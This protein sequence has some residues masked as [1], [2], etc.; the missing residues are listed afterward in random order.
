MN[1][2]AL[3]QEVSANFG[4][5]VETR[6]KVWVNA[7][8]QEWLNRR[9]WSYLETT[10][11]A[12]ALVA[13][14]QNYVLLGSSPVVTDYNGMI[15][16]ELEVTASGARVPLR[17]FDPQ[18]FVIC[19]SHS[20]VN[21]VPAF[22]ATVGG[23]AQVSAAT[24]LSGGNQ[25]LALW[26]IPIATAGNGVNVFLRYTRMVSETMLMTATTDVPIIPPKDHFALV[27]GAAAIGFETFGQESQAQYAR[28]K[29]QQRM[30][31]AAI[32]DEGMRMR[33]I[34]RVQLVQQPWQYPIT[35]APQNGA[36]AANDPYPVKH[37]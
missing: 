6:A 27:H 23:T 1:F 21:G 28:M 11:A 30:E 19:T 7:A 37:Q 3:F 12:I 16:V 20:R 4:T 29:F 32:D 18:D 8:Y 13:S 14:Q 15:S 35:G 24:I 5:T 22:W 9:K 31:A 25:A 10:S 33:D 26:P 17:E 36:P 2:Q 34:Q